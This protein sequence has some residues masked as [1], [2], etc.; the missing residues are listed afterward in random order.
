MLISLL[1][2]NQEAELMLLLRTIFK[3][4]NLVYLYGN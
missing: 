1:V 2:S 4:T 3:N